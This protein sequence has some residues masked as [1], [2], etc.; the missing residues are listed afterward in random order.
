MKT[1]YIVLTAMMLFTSCDNDLEQ[2][3]AL[4]LESSNLEVY[5]PVL[6]AAYYY[7]TGVAMS[8]VVLGDFR[9][10]NMLMLEDP[11]TSLDT[12]DPD[13]SGGDMTEA[14]FN[15]IYTNLYKSILSANNVIENSSESTEVAEA[16]FLRGL[17]YF[18]L[19][20]IFGDVAVNLS[21]TPSTSDLSILE[22][23]PTE[24]I[25]NNVIIPDFQDAIAG[26]DNSGLEEGR[27]TQ[28]AA[29]AFL[30]KV[31]MHRNNFTSAVTELAAV[32]SGASAAGVSL[33]ANFEDVVTDLSSER[34]FAT[35]LSTSVSIADGS[36]ISSTFVGWF[37][38]ADTKS[39][40]P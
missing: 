40:T 8:Q 12:Y 4:D 22:R 35:Q 31:Y 28:I 34:L 32:V 36:S 33:E 14:F 5:G 16:K 10:D 7:H 37:E 11:F 20:T 13:L 25:Y 26:L 24:D 9:A 21:A 27:A 30:G 18:K 15:P 23:Q 38:G 17:S 29:R 39:L 6:N 3:P 19:V 2:T 1:I